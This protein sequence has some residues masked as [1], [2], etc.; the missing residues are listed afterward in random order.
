[1][2][3]KKISG[4]VTDDGRLGMFISKESGE[5]TPPRDDP[6]PEVWWPCLKLQP[7][8]S[9]LELNDRGRNQNKIAD[10]RRQKQDTVTHGFNQAETP[11]QPKIMARERFQLFRL[12]NAQTAKGG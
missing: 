8:N 4:G 5:D 9:A 3:L 11:P 1:M 10:T 2:K 12:N 7:W 6:A